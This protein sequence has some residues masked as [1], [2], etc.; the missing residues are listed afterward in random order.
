MTGQGLIEETIKLRRRGADEPWLADSFLAGLPADSMRRL[1]RCGAVSRT[2]ARIDLSTGARPA[3]IVLNGVVKVFHTRWDG[4][5]TLVQVAGVGD[6]L[7]LDGTPGTA[8]RLVDGWRTDVL[9]IP[10]QRFRDLC[11]RDDEINDALVRTLARRVQEL[12]AQLG[13]SGRR[14]EH[15]LWAFLVALA[16]RQGERMRKD[17][18]LEIGLTQADL[19]A[20]IGATTNSVE[21]AVRRLRETERISTGY[22]LFILHSLPDEEELDREFS[23]GVVA[24][25]A[26][27]G[28]PARGPGPASPRPAG[29]RSGPAAAPPC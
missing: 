3:V 18:W 6:L 15:R 26:P 8:V 27:A 29:T 21:V 16:R 7:D 4:R 17:I 22:A 14:V 2:S 9:V 19:A 23:R 11:V 12:T 28:S 24:A 20:A 13:H 1:E 5:E 25:A 10:R